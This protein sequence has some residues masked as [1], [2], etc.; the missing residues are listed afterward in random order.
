MLSFGQQNFGDHMRRGDK[1]NAAFQPIAC[2]LRNDVTVSLT[3][4]DFGYT[5]SSQ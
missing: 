4:I 1:A 3:V 2:A 5:T